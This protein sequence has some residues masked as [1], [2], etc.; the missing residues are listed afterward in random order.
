MEKLQSL[1]LRSK[2]WKVLLEYDQEEQELLR[3]LEEIKKMING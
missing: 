1:K 2:Y 3:H